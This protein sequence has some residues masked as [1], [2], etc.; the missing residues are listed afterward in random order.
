VQR[1]IRDKRMKYVWNLTD[2]DELYDLESDPWEL[3]NLVYS[4]E[5]KAE[6]VRLRKALYED[7][8]QRKDPLIWQNAA[9]R[10]L[11]DNKKL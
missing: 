10:Q 6:L 3:N 1:M 4:K 11:I 7:L 8:K 2:T 5:Y 9:K